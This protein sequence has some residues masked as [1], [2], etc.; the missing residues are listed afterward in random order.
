MDTLNEALDNLHNALR[1]L[2]RSIVETLMARWLGAVAVWQ[3]LCVF[4]ILVAIAVGV[5]QLLG[6]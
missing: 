2:R 5:S 4:W 6:I 3:V 1:D